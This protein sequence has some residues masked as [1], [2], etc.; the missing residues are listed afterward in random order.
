MG[1]YLPISI[2]WVVLDIFKICKMGNCAF[3][4]GNYLP[5]SI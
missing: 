5:I 2:N 4:M 3:K 1:N